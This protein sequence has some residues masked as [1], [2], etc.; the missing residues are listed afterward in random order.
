[1]KATWNGQTLAES[2]KTVEVEGTQYFPRDSV[3]WQLFSETKT[4]TVCPWKGTASYYTVTVDGKANRDAA[5]TYGT[6]KDA[7][8]EI[9]GYLAFWSGVEVGG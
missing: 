3:N 6:P 4:S 7:A 8:A 5:W 1:M 9:K 2:D